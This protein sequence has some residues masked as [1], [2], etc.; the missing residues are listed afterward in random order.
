MNEM[1][2]YMRTIKHENKLNQERKERKRT[3]QT[4][5]IGTS[6]WSSHEEISENHNG[7]Y[8]VNPSV[9]WERVSI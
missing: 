4:D 5:A 9:K 6:L 1:N 7:E 8:F 2:V 3:K